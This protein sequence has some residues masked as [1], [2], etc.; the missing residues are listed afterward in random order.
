MQGGTNIACCLAL[1]GKRFYGEADDDENQRPLFFQGWPT[2][3]FDAGPMTFQMQT[4]LAGRAPWFAGFARL[5]N[6]GGLQDHV[7]KFVQ[8]VFLVS[9]LIAK[10]LRSD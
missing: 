6:Y 2:A 8:A 3:L 10:S 5:G 9:F 7:P 1:S 4:A